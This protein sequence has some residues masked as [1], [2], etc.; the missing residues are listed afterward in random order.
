MSLTMHAGIV[1]ALM[2]GV[3]FTPSRGPVP[4]AVIEAVV[5]DQAALDRQIERLREPDPAEVQARER[6]ERE[7]DERV[8]AQRRE[9]EL[10]AERLETARVEQEQAEIALE[11][12]RAESERI[13]RETSEREAADEAQRRREAEEEA[14]RLEAQRV[15]DLER[16]RQE[17]A[18]REQEAAEAR[19]QAEMER[20][21]QAALDAEEELRALRESSEFDRYLLQIRSRIEANWIPPASAVAGLECVVNVTQIASGDVVSVTVGRC[22]GDAAVKRSIETAVLRSSPLPTPSVPALFERNLELIFKPVF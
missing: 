10:E 13:E 9:R 22:N 5:V 18:R 12:D 3:R 1:A 8:E 17:A 15:A 11:R 2:L 7:A 4:Q 21:L 20:E 6:E 14:A 19:L 16:E